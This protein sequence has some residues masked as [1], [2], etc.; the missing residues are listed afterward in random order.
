MYNEVGEKI[1][2]LAK[3]LA[4]IGIMGAVIF[5]IMLINKGVE[6]SEHSYS[7]EALGTTYTILG[8]VVILGGSLVSWLS[9]LTLYG[10]GELVDR[11]ISIDRKLSDNRNNNVFLEQSSSVAEKNDAEKRAPTA[12]EELAQL[13]SKFNNGEISKKEYIKRLKEFCN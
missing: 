2:K 6:L 9:Y 10:F 8:I 7:S 11:A 12:S 1:K 3:V 13:K 4:I 5:G